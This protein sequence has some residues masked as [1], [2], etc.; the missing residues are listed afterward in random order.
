MH[1]DRLAAARIAAHLQRAPKE[2]GLSK[3]AQAI[4]IVAACQRV[5]EIAKRALDEV[6]A[7]AEM[8]GIL[9]ANGVSS[10]NEDAVRDAW[11]I[12]HDVLTG[13][14]SEIGGDAHGYGWNAR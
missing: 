7:I 3:A 11:E 14:S 8:A 4:E 10:S 13:W 1:S 6:A 9:L 5:P 12:Y 2:P